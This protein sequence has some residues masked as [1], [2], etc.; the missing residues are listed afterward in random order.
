MSLFFQLRWIPLRCTQQ[1]C[2]LLPGAP[3]LRSAR[4]LLVVKLPLF[5]STLASCCPLY[6]SR[7]EFRI[8]EVADL[9][10][11][12][13]PLLIP[14]ALLSA[15]LE[16][17]LPPVSERPSLLELFDVQRK[18][19]S[20]SKVTKSSSTSPSGTNSSSPGDISRVCLH[21]DAELRANR[22]WVRDASIFVYL[23]L[24]FV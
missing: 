11:V 22:A 8:E 15:H 4:K 14:I 23:F 20:S 13:P 9:V 19:T 17:P 7:A 24:L 6:Q 5:P 21:G 10:E 3:L 16:S 2:Q 18:L 12:L 1:Y